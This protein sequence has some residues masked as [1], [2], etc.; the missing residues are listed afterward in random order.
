[1]RGVS[2]VHSDDMRHAS[3]D[4]DM[5]NLTFQETRYNY[6]DLLQKLSLPVHLCFYFGDKTN[7][8]IKKFPIYYTVK[9]HCR[10]YKSPPITPTV[11]R[12]NPIHISFL[13]TTPYIHLRT[14]L[15]LLSLQASRVKSVSPHALHIQSASYYFNHRNNS[16]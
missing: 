5:L 3:V 2:N 16:W 15:T 12:L 6:V 7:E 8:L 4:S 9:F 1:V 13:S 14:G 10:V 11:C